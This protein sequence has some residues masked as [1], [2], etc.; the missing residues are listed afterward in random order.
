MTMA[1]DDYTK[2]PDGELAVGLHDRAPQK[3][4]ARKP[5]KK[6]AKA[7]VQAD[8][9]PRWQNRI[10]GY[11]TEN[12][13]KLKA[14]SANW[15]EHP[16]AQR[17]AM[18]SVF[19]TIG[20]TQN[21]VLNKRTGNTIDGHLRVELAIEDKEPRVPVTYVD[22]SPEEEKVSLASFDSLGSMATTNTDIL[23]T[24]VASMAGQVK[25]GP[26]GAFLDSMMEDPARMNLGELT[27][28][29]GVSERPLQHP[30]NPKLFVKF[31][32]AAIDIRE[33]EEAIRMTGIKNR[34]DAMKEVCK[35]HLHAKRK[36]SGLTEGQQ[37]TGL[38]GS[39]SAEML[40]RVELPAGRP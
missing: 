7:Q 12:P 32:I 6:N 33:I 39:V 21:V 25:D 1:Q 11:G 37:R 34:G 13:A 10:T 28:A 35:S 5:K 3:K 30:Q 24:L 22:L 9:P 15:R 19:S 26:L 2:P 38:E 14:H 20:W 31:V 40:G 23:S 4:K 8:E 27:E 29:Q 18:R 16:G 17:A 36:E